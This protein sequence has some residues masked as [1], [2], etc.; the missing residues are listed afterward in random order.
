MSNKLYGIFT[1]PCHVEKLVNYLNKYTDIDYI[2]STSKQDIK[3]YSFD[4]G[5]SYCFPYIIDI[6]DIPWYNYHPAPLPEYPGINC[7]SHA[8]HDRVRRYGV[9]LHQMTNT[10]D[11][12]EIIEKN[13]FDLVEAP[14]CVDELGSI[15]HYYLFQLFKKTI[16]KLK[17]LR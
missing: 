4:I 6:K 7:Y 16:N 17:E 2:I 3:S 15:A 8:I 12:G 13:M 14:C 5:I 9:T 11:Q 10:V 1:K